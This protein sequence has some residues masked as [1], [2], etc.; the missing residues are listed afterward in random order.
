MNYG[1]ETEMCDVTSV[2]AKYV[3]IHNERTCNKSF[4]YRIPCDAY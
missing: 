1:D 2:L 4:K 3:F